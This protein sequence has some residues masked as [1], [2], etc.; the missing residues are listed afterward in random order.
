MG[1]RWRCRKPSARPPP[2]SYTCTHFWS[3]AWCV[4]PR[5]SPD[6][7]AISQRS[8]RR[9]RVTVS[10]GWSVPQVSLWEMD[11]KGGKKKKRKSQTSGSVCWNG[12]NPLRAASYP[13]EEKWHQ[14]AQTQES[15]RL[16]GLFWKKE[17]K[18]QPKLLCILQHVQP[19]C[20][21]WTPP[22]PFLV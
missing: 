4:V 6:V 11:K 12:V 16:F 18:K 13:L 9:Y 3:V 21:L 20:N 14:Q 7:S 1:S 22:L 17:K 5:H 15:C 10:D 8:P 19:W 2:H